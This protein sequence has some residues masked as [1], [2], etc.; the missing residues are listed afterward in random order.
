M[1]DRTVTAVYSF[2]LD[3]IFEAANLKDPDKFGITYERGSFA[4]GMATEMS[5][6][7]ITITQ[8]NQGIRESSVERLTYL[9]VFV[10]KGEGTW[11]VLDE[12]RY[13]KTVV[14]TAVADPS[15]V[16]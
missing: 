6:V 9:V 5:P 10:E 15:K 1:N 4:L 13:Q 3:E 2:T 7:F 12:E 14:A 11:A 16:H 8:I